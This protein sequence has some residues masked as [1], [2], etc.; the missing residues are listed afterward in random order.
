MTSLP[1]VRHVALMPCRG[2]ENPALHLHFAGPLE[3]HHHAIIFGELSAYI[4][5]RNGQTFEPDFGEDAV[6]FRPAG[7]QGHFDEE[8]FVALLRHFGFELIGDLPII[9]SDQCRSATDSHEGEVRHV[10]PIQATRH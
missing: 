8:H 6:L 5:E 1:A 4:I 10:A 3:P 9:G 2:E 7:N